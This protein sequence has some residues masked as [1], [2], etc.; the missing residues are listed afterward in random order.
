MPKINDLKAGTGEHRRDEALAQIMDVAFDYADHN[1]AGL[2]SSHALQAWLERIERC[3]KCSCG[4][5]NLGQIDLVLLPQTT[6]LFNAGYD[7]VIQNRGGSCACRQGGF[8][9][10][11]GQV[12]VALY[13]RL[14][15]A[16][17][18]WCLDLGHRQPP[19]EPIQLVRIPMTSRWQRAR[20]IVPQSQVH[21]TATYSI[22][23]KPIAMNGRTTPPMTS[24]AEAPIPPSR[25]C[26]KRRPGDGHP[27]RR[28]GDG[29]ETDLPH[30][31]RVTLE[32][33]R[34]N[35]G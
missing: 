27:R 21:L 18:F 20:A 33:L 16:F 34:L 25:Y 23:L 1:P 4:E 6:G 29:E 2:A 11:H 17:H 7:G 14:A 35:R 26:R 32:L 19:F 13:D 10:V 9:A 28:G 30:A 15:Y 5:N 3:P 24:P 12:V 22:E 8:D 31:K